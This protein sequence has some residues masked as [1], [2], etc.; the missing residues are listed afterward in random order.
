MGVVFNIKKFISFLLR[1]DLLLMKWMQNLIT[2]IER[3]VRL[4]LFSFLIASRL[5]HYPWQATFSA[6]HPALHSCFSHLQCY[7]TGCSPS[8]P[9]LQDGV[10]VAGMPGGALC[11][12]GTPNNALDFLLQGHRNAKLLEN[13]KGS[14]SE[15]V[16][17]GLCYH[18]DYRPLLY[19]NGRN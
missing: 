12:L 3:V 2:L 14:I 4:S 19:P 6:Q 18:R 15:P 5:L 16:C 8:F 17:D 1:F 9:E 10:G 13:M 7:R 11:S